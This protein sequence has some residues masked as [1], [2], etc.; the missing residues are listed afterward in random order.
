MYIWFAGKEQ[1][2]HGIQNC[3][4]HSYDIK[5]SLEFL[6]PSP[7]IVWINMFTKI[8]DISYS[9][10]HNVPIFITIFNTHNKGEHII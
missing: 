3:N 4:L 2:S 1:H 6:A 8:F 9:I 7:L 10:L 5:K